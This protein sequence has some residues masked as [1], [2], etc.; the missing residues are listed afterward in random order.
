MD[1][2]GKILKFISPSSLVFVAR[3]ASL[4]KGGLPRGAKRRGDEF[5]FDKK[6]TFKNGWG[7]SMRQIEKK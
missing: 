3:F 2:D 1:E 5:G 4:K 6:G 7:A